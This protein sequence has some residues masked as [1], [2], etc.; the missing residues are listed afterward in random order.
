MS[1]AERFGRNLMRARM[2][3]DLSQEEVG[4]R[5]SLHRTEIGLLERGER[6]PRIDTAIKLAAAVDVPLDQLFA[7]IRWEPGN[8][9]PG[10]FKVAGG[11]ASHDDAAEAAGY[12]P[13]GTSTR[14]SCAGQDG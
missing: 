11:M 8:W 10:E 3:A 6:I 4:I 9:R 14:E 12:P 5:A 1:I 13:G 2:D 7:G